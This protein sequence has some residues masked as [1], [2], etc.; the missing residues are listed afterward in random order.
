MSNGPF[1]DSKY[2]ADDDTVYGIKVQP[3]TLSLT[4]NSV[5]N[6]PPAGAV[7]GD[8]LA[9]V[10][11]SRRGY[12][13]FARVGRFRITASGTSGL[14]VGRVITLPLLNGDIY[15]ECKKPNTGTYNTASVAVV[16]RS[17]EVIR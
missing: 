1:Q 9:R 11:G 16:G 8:V 13:V 12:G 17:G 4:I 5:Q 10:T 14:A 6:D 3:E 15:D 7:T 2:A